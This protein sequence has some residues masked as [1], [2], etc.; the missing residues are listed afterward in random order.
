MLKAEVAKGK[1]GRVIVIDSITQVK[2]EDKRLD[3]GVRVARRG[4][5]GRIR[6]RGAAEGWRSST[7]PASAR[8]APGS[9]RLRCCRRRASAAGAVAHT[10]ARIGD[11]GDM[12]ENGVISYVNATARALGLT[13]GAKLRTAL[14]ELVSR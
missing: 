12:W 9:R 4:E 10:S 11:S 6:A 5:L 7:M 1:G 14:T 13:T 2:P 8:T 3:C